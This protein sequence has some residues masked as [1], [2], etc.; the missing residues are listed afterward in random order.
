MAILTTQLEV[1]IRQLKKNGY[2]VQRD[3]GHTTEEGFATGTLTI[4][5]RDKQGFGIVVEVNLL[6]DVD[7]D[8]ELRKMFGL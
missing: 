3:G 7:H 8:A 1:I 6:S 4:R 2:T 5:Y